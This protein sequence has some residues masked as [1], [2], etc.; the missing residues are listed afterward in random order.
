MQR[1]VIRI[2]TSILTTQCLKQ[3]LIATTLLMD[4]VAFSEDASRQ[5]EFFEA[6]IRPVLIEHCY[7]CHSAKSESP[8]GG[9]L[10]D[11]ANG[12]LTGGDSGPAI[13]PG[14]PNFSP[15]IEAIRYEGVEMPPA[16][17][18]PEQTIKNFEQWV[19]SG[20]FD[21]RDDG[22]T[23][24]TTNTIDVEAGR[25]FW[26]FR[27]IVD[28]AVPQSQQAPKQPVDAF[29]SARHEVAGLPVAPPA[30]N[31]TLTRRLHFDL[32]GLPP[33]QNSGDENEASAPNQ[34]NIATLVDELLNSKQFGEHWGRHWLDVAR[35]ADSNGN[36]FNAT[37]HDA[38]KY[39]DYVVNAFNND[40]PFD[41]FIKEQIA[42]DLL[43]F[44]SDSEKTE[45]I[46]A[47]GFL[48][49][50]TKMLSE[51]DKEKLRMDVVDEQINTFG[52]AFLGM[53]LGCARCHDHKFDPVPTRDYYALA[54]IFRS[55]RTL[56]GESQ[57]YVSTWKRTSLPT[58]TEHIDAVNSWQAHKKDLESQLATAKKRLVE[59]KKLSPADMPNMVDN[60]EATLVGEWRASTSSPTF[61]GTN[62]IHDNQSNKGTMSVTFPWQP[63]K[64][65]TYELQVSYVGGPTRANNVP[66]RVTHANGESAV[67]LDQSTIPEID[68]MFRAVGR[69]EFKKDV[70]AQVTISNTGT[71]GYVIVDAI[72]FRALNSDDD[73]AKTKDT[74]NEENAKHPEGDK[75][76]KLAACEKLIAT[77][78]KEIKQHKKN[79][80]PALPYA[81]A[82]TDLPEIEDCEICI[83]GEHDNRGQQVAR[84]FLQVATSEEVPTL[85]STESG[86]QELA[87]W[88]ASSSNPLTARVIVNRVWS[89]LLG[90]GIV[91]SVDNFGKLG[92]EPSHPELLDYLAI[93]FMTPAGTQ[94]KFGAE[95]MGW[96]I[97]TLIREIV[98]SE[99]YQRSCM[100]NDEAFGI[101]PENRLLWKAN[102]RRLPAE[103]LRDAILAISGS[104]TLA[105][106]GSPVEGLGTLVKTNDATASDYVA[107][108]SYHRSL[109]LPI[110]RSELPPILTV[111]DFADP[112]MVVGKRA[113]TNVPAQALFVMNSPFVMSNAQAVAEDLCKSQAASTIAESNIQLIQAAYQ[114]V[115][116]RSATDKE[117]ER[118]IEFLG[119]FSND[120]PSDEPVVTRLSRLIHV[121]FASTEFRMLD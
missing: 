42:G 35:Y 75:T 65:S 79:E 49:L 44:E 104:L 25:S 68:G 8:K 85:P 21:P 57:K 89:K 15:L 5:L 74:V 7:E 82:V 12:L 14:K 88:I 53:T 50:G 45:H 6:H 90:Q 39:R 103:S 22:P 31:T 4:N 33:Q 69:F 81:I 101:D 47:T 120:A 55:T 3:I 93:R 91:R 10:L 20:A 51:R 117:V 48:M 66:I 72:R 43:P 105:P 52:T 115:L 78:E 108:E 118:A 97:K 95:G 96:S 70:V 98:L 83:R 59:L 16:Q 62:Y 2:A 114:K 37:F 102:R 84:G 32:T 64:T 26:A 119:D 107:T 111:F 13:Q 109:Y 41:E 63:S 67:T 92:D 56:Q 87:N 80:P 23:P 100:H 18:L 112:D 99:T 40:K 77:L 24:T 1:Y 76:N 36:D 11:T 17:K 19:R 54:G 61:V 38:W 34:T 86:R 113:E 121:M 116:F 71:T 73:Y 94:T 27:P 60:L 28:H 58:S 30:D 29:I 9:L 106:A 46:I 110:I